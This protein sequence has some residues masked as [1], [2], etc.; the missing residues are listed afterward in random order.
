[1]RK[2]ILMSLFIL[3][4]GITFV[5]AENLAWDADGDGKNDAL[6]D[7][8]LIF[9][10]LFE[11]TG[12]NLIKDAIS[13]GATRTTSDAVTTYLNCLKG[14]G[15]L[16]VDGDGKN[17]AL[18]DGFLI[19]RYLFGFTGDELTKDAVDPAGTR[20]TSD[21]IV[22]F[23]NN[24]PGWYE[25]ACEVKSGCNDSDDGLNYFVKGTVTG[26]NEDAPVKGVT[27]ATDT[28]DGNNLY[29]FICKTSGE[30][31]DESYICPNGCLNGVCISSNRITCIDSDNGKNPSQKG[32]VTLNGGL[33]WDYCIIDKPILVEKYCSNGEIKEA[34]YQCLGGCSDGICIGEAIPLEVEAFPEDRCV[35]FDNGEN[36]YVRGKIKGTFQGNSTFEDEDFCS[37]YNP[38]DPEGRDVRVNSCS[39]YPENHCSVRE[40]LCLSDE[41]TVSATSFTCIYG[42][43]SGACFERPLIEPDE[44]NKIIEVPDE[45]ISNYDCKGCKDNDKCYFFGYR[46]AKEYCSDKG[47]F[48]EQAKE[49]TTCDNNFEC[50]SNVCISGQCIS[51][52]LIQKILNWFRKVFERE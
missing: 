36:Y 3:M 45:I 34:N 17:N 48:V 9:R 14:L 26:Q 42:C 41:K 37:L 43:K 24:P 31:D 29:E 10:Y 18:T 23:L 40:Y 6:S 22:A 35:D 33:F 38:N 39:Q 16:D 51:E 5:S 20:L 4:I 46:K 44:T 30:Y 49:E 32:N 19:Q 25:G 27:S 21:K 12:D 11:I 52:G 1:M 47:S 13:T 7:G 15:V 50:S 8:I 28:C 2:I